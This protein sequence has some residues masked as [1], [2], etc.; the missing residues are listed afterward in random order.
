MKITAKF[1]I[2]AVL[3][4]ICINLVLFYHIYKKNPQKITNLT[5]DKYISLLDFKFPTNPLIS[6][7]VPTYNSIEFIKEAVE[8][9]LKQKYTNFELIIVNDASTDSTKD[10]LE[11][12]KDQRVKI[13]HHEKNKKLPSALNTGFTHSK[14]EFLTWISS[15]NICT[16]DFLEE[17]FK[18]AK[19][20]KELK[21]LYSDYYVINDKGRVLKDLRAG[22]AVTNGIFHGGGARYNFKRTVKENGGVAAFLYPRDV[23]EKIGEYDPELVG[24][25][26]WDYW[27]RILEWIPIGGYLPKPLM[28]YRIHD[29][30]MS[31]TMENTVYQ[32][33]SKMLEK[34]LERHGSNL[35][36]IHLIYPALK[37]CVE[38]EKSKIVAMMKYADDL[39]LGKY[40]QQMSFDYQKKILEENVRKFYNF[41]NQVNYAISLSINNKF[42]ESLNIVKNIRIEF[43]QQQTTFNQFLL[44]IEN[45]EKI[46]TLNN[47]RTPKFLKPHPSEEILIKQEL[48][49]NGYD[50]KKTLM[51]NPKGL[52]VF[53][54]S[55]KLNEITEAKLNQD[56]V[57]KLFDPY[58]IFDK[59]SYFF[60]EGKPLLDFEN[61]YVFSDQFQLKGLFI[62]NNIDVVLIFSGNNENCKFIKDHH[63][64]MIKL[65]SDTISD[66]CKSI[67][68]YYLIYNEDNLL[69]ILEKYKIPSNRIISLPNS[70]VFSFYEYKVEK[71]PHKYDITIILTSEN[72]EDIQ[73]II[74]SFQNKLFLL[75]NL[76][77][78][79]PKEQFK[80]LKKNIK[81]KTTFLEI[82]NVLYIKSIQSTFFIYQLKGQ[83]SESIQILKFLMKMNSLIISIDNYPNNFYIQNNITGFL[84]KSIQKDFLN[85]DQFKKYKANIEYNLQ[86]YSNPFY[87]H[88]LDLSFIYRMILASNN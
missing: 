74:E 51:K 46:S 15:D 37:F 52:G 36:S 23:L 28:Y 69:L 43:P 7:I 49:E 88:N 31:K 56:Q 38:K 10:Y 55:S 65:D 73:S 24:T 85:F 32:R 22:A 26:D 53:L 20:F 62:E 34:R 42:K 64:V 2:F 78:L 86:T 35:F 9:V 68:N 33:E 80:N 40:S 84:V 72:M 71:L 12:I 1:F 41:E 30:S 50:L 82:D 81:G 77:D 87:N 13:I 39:T 79:Y 83:S 58:L 76:K 29:K 16:N 54:S 5:L 17:M 18:T 70:D 8:S 44:F 63:K 48:L 19:E 45:Y 4:I 75:I 11:K 66:S 21:Y 27:L 47:K 67:G 3:I 57:R 60:E 59:I 6:V 14:G 61:S 25:E